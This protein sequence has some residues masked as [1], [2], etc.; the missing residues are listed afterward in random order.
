VADPVAVTSRG[1]VRGT[2]VGDVSA[3]L[4][5]PYAAPPVARL[6]FRPPQPAAAWSGERDCRSL[7]AACPQPGLP[8]LFDRLDPAAPAT[9]FVERYDEDCLTV[10]VWT[11]SLRPGDR[12]VM[13]WLHGGWF[14]VGSGNEPTCN[15]ANL[16]AA[17][18]VV[19]VTVN[20]RLGALGF[21]A[22]AEIGGDPYAESANHG[23]LDVVAALEWVRDNA[24]AFGGDPGRVT[25]FG[26][27]GGAAKVSALLAVDRARG[28]FHR[29]VLQSGPMLR[30]VP[31][32]S[33]A[34][35]AR[36]F[37]DELGIDGLADLG[38]VPTA[39][40]LRAQNVV[41]GGPLG[42]TYG[43]RRMAPTL[44]HAVIHAH[45]FDPAAAPPAREIPLLIGSCR[46]E[47]SMLLASVPE[48]AAAGPDEQVTLLAERVFGHRFVP[49]VPEY[50][51][52]RPD[53][54]PLDCFLAVTSDQLRVG[55]IHI[56]ERATAAGSEVFM[57][58]LDHV[59]P[60][61]G[62]RLGA[63][64]TLDV[65]FVF[66][67]I[68]TGAGTTSPNRGLYQD[69]V[70]P[71]LAEEMSRAW[72]TFARDGAPGRVGPTRWP[73]YEPARRSTMIFA[74]ES[75]VVDDPNG[76]ERELWIGGAAGM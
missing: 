48:L 26:E 18:D 62:G 75:H 59:P 15:G 58:R 66:R 54:S 10:N 9:K 14:S 11:P 69:P 73:R 46:N 37:F 21:L 13:V 22:L 20:H 51:R 36:A 2:R 41:L 53:D 38:K 57:Y 50:R 64:H 6:R 40:I 32:E 30:V 71:G 3:F 28:L 67:N 63:M 39:E 25:V 60:V 17:G 72:V 7:P 33:A 29:A 19:V 68:D 45:P 52:L 35:T 4:G 44:D 70:A 56:A 31:R 27:S 47:S 34:R 49:M 61:Y 76:R 43:E 74:A 23:I 55:G 65:G 5:I 8:R 12:P 24:A 16:A 42:G 1:T